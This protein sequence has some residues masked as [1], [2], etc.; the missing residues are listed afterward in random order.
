MVFAASNPLYQFVECASNHNIG[1]LLVKS[2]VT[3]A[4]MTFVPNID[5]I[6]GTNLENTTFLNHT[7]SFLYTV[8]M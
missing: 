8:G 1:F 2:E 6:Y 4:I 5:S 7:N 3:L